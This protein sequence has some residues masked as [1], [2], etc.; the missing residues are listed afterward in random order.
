MLRFSDD[1]EKNPAFFSSRSTVC[2]AAHLQKVQVLCG[3]QVPVHCLRSHS[4]LRG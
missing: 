3:P 2:S 4:E 1:I